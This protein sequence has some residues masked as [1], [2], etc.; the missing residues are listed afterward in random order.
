MNK[1]IIFGLLAIIA[2]IFIVVYF[3][4]S[5][6]GSTVAEPEETTSEKVEMSVPEK[7]EKPVV[8]L[9]GDALY[10]SK[11][12]VAC[13]GA[14]AKTP[15]MPS[16]PKLAGQ[17]KDYAVAQMKDI[18]SGARNNGQTAAMKAIMGSVSDAEMEAIA[19]WLASLPKEGGDATLAANGATLYNNKGCTACHGADAQTPIMPSYPK[20]AGQGKEYAVAQMKD[21]KSGARNNGLTAV[22]KGIMA[23]VS[24][25]EMEDIAEWLV[26]PM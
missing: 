17:G 12:C 10:N 14:D 18:K 7:V 9:D 23:S 4:P 19:E 20:L 24:D 22:M 25:A 11:G 1:T 2:V 8:K 16:Y 3:L 21:I 26:S 5:K 6:K 15:I 13:H